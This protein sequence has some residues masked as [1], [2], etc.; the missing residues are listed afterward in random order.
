MKNIHTFSSKV[1]TPR[2]VAAIYTGSLFI[3]F[4]VLASGVKALDELGAAEKTTKIS[5]SAGSEPR[6][7]EGYE[8][9]CR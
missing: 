7:I 6:I 3:L 8:P 9:T 4:A 2:Q 5:I 1:R